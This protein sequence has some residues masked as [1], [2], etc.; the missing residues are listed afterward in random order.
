MIELTNFELAQVG[1]DIIF[2]VIALWC[3]H[4]LRNYRRMVQV[5]TAES[6]ATPTD[7]KLIDEWA[8]KYEAL[9]GGPKKTA[10]RNRLLEVGYLD[11]GCGKGSD[12]D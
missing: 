2:L 1:I 11:V 12:G 8:K 10:Y 3:I 5:M 6:L 4:H 9:P 7:P